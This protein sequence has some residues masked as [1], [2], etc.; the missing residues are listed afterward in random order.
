[1]PKTLCDGKSIRNPLS[2]QG[3]YY[4]NRACIIL[5]GQEH[6]NPIILTG[7]EHQNLIILTGHILCSKVYLH[8][9]Q[10]PIIETGHVMC[11]KVYL[12]VHQ[13]PIIETGHV[14]CSKVYLH[15]HQNPIIKTGHVLCSK[16]YALSGVMPL[17]ADG[18]VHAAAKH[19]VVLQWASEC[20]AHVGE[21]GSTCS[22]AS[23]VLWQ[24]TSFLSKAHPIC[25]RYTV[26]AICGHQTD[27]SVWTNCCYNLI[28]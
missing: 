18:A 1:M 11:S 5:T 6:Q 13:N 17:R 14:L 27:R 28:D 26:A 19:G 3:M 2:K 15:V 23:V 8:V 9:H 22:R 21:A 16:V 4:P 10:N 25:R 20:C 24:G 7:Q 12:H